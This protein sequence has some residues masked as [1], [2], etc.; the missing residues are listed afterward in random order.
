[1]YVHIYRSVLVLNKAND[2]HTHTSPCIHT[3]MIDIDP[4]ITIARSVTKRLH[5]EAIGNWRAAGCEVQD[6]I[7]K[8][9]I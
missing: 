5:A 8:F 1:M 6:E 2:Q 4:Y 9:E 3:C 7:H